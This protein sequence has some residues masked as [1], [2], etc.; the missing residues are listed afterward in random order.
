MIVESYR[1]EGLA[2]TINALLCHVLYYTL[3]VMYCT[4]CTGTDNATPRGRQRPRQTSVLR[5]D[6]HIITIRICLFL[7]WS[8]SG[9][10][11]SIGFGGYSAFVRQWTL[12]QVVNTRQ[13][14][15]ESIVH[16][17]IQPQ[18]MEVQWG[19]SYIFLRSVWVPMATCPLSSEKVGAAT[20]PVN[21]AATV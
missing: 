21:T 18:K 11:G 4:Q 5:K 13:S 16:L 17:T 9:W 15:T 7:S 3:T 14:N 10:L 20:T 2:S 8:S 1:P 12:S 19:P 6:A